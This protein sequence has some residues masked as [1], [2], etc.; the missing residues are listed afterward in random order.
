M[1]NHTSK[2]ETDVRNPLQAWQK[3]RELY[4]NSVGCTLD[5]HVGDARSVIVPQNDEKLARLECDDIARLHNPVGA[6]LGARRIDS[7]GHGWTSGGNWPESIGSGKRW[8]EL[9][10]FA[11][12]TNLINVGP[13]DYRPHE[14]SHQLHEVSFGAS[15]SD[16]SNNEE[17]DGK[18]MPELETT[19]PKECGCSAEYVPGEDESKNGGY[20]A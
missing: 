14:Q 9:P 18:G 7:P 12:Q 20:P 1:L 15:A 5:T 4:V 19:E 2:Y 13:A 3:A 17:D 10:P 16:H 11:T 6:S 8:N